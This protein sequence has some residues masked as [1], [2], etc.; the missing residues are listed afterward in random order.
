MALPVLLRAAL[1][2]LSF[3]GLCS[4]ARSALKLDRFIAPC[5]CACS[6]ICVLMFSGML[7]AL[8]HGFYLLYFGGFAA[9]LP[10]FIRRI[11]KGGTPPSLSRS[12]C[13]FAACAALLT[14]Y[15][16]WR[17]LPSRLHETDDFSHWAIAA[18][19]LLTTDAFPDAGAASITFQS[20]PLGSAVFIY[21]ICRT[22]VSTEGMWMIAQNLL[23]VLLFLPVLSHIRGNRRFVLPV[24]AALFVLLFKHTRPMEALYVDWLL[25]FFCI[26]AVAAIF[27]YHDD[28]RKALLVGIPSIIAV[29]YVK[30]SGMFFAAVEICALTTVC[31]KKGRA[32][33]LRCFL[34][35]T[36]ILIGA[37][38]LWSTHV[39]LT[40]PHGLDTK[41]AISLSTYAE[42]F[43]SKNLSLIVTTAKKMILEWLRPDF[44]QVQG[45]L[46]IA[47]GYL[48]MLHVCRR[49]PELAN[50]LKP[51]RRAFFAILLVYAAWY[52]ML[53]A[54]YVF[55]MRANEART[56]AAFDRYNG[57]G[58]LMICGLSLIVLLRFFA[59]DE[60]RVPGKRLL[61]PV[62]IAAI[63]ATCAFVKP[64]PHPYPFY[65]QL[66]QRTTERCETR[67]L[68]HGI[69]SGYDL[70]ADSRYLVL[71]PDSTS[72]NYAGI[73]GRIYFDL[74]FE[75]YTPHITILGRIDP[76]G[77]DARFFYGTQD[78]KQYPADP[79][80][81]IEEDFDAFDAIIVLS[82]DNYFE[83]AIAKL[84]E[85]HGGKT[86]IHA[87]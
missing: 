6:V 53:F 52:L 68:A 7:H 18:R 46:F 61:C 38:W 8:K 42:R 37:Y 27:Y 78:L 55:S 54:T 30:N 19:H 45:L 40:F 17:L 77:D 76:D 63:L 66:L 4:A 11:R 74:K 3:L 20:Y 50:G 28:P 29:V 43:R 69:Y 32:S 82:E 59:R 48:S 58:L 62:L 47:L 51:A 49:Q 22:L 72:Q 41:H 70:P 13:F 16:L 34:A 87:Y 33:G 12:G 23:M 83:D 2:G 65:P 84:A 15:L 64:G 35:C 67:Q 60:V 1:L 81:L 25:A 24:T 10:G 56:L 57:T 85:S 44:Y 14:A 80:P 75:L 5:F 9:L 26:G 71:G 31:G 79:I 86:V 39:K 21:Y 36:A 73:Y